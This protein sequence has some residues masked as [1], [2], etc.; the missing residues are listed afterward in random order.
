[1]IKKIQLSS[2]GKFRNCQIPCGPVTVIEGANESGKTTLFDALLDGLCKPKGSTEP[3]KLLRQRYGDA[4]SVNLE[5]DGPELQFSSV[6][7]LNLFAIRAGDLSVEVS[8]D[9]EWLSRV[10]AQLFSG[11]IDPLAVAEQLTRQIESRA[12]GTL[13]AEVRDLQEKVASL[14]KTLQELQQQRELSLQEEKESIHSEEEL[15]R[16]QSELG[17]L[18]KEEESLI[19]SLEQQNLYRARKELFQVKGFLES[20]DKLQQELEEMPPYTEEEQRELRTLERE[21][22]ELDSQIQKTRT[23]LEEARKELQN[24]QPEIEHLSGQ[25]RKLQQIRD[26]GISLKTRLQDRSS[27]IDRKVLYTFRPIFLVLAALVFLLGVA[28]AGVAPKDLWILPLVAGVVGAALLAFFGIKRESVE[29]DTRFRK[30]V[31]GVCEE[32]MK[33]G[34]DP[35]PETTWENF[36][37]TLTRTDERLNNNRTQLEELHGKEGSIRNRIEALEGDLARYRHE[38]EEIGAALRVKCERLKVRD[39][40]HY[41]AQMEKRSEKESRLRELNHLIEEA[42]KRYGQADAIGLGSCVREELERIQR[43]ITEP[44]KPEAEVKR[45]EN[46]LRQRKERRE[47]LESEEKR[48]IQLVHR[49]KG[50]VSGAYRDLPERIVKTE[51]ELSRKKACVEEKKRSWKGARRAAELFRS[52]SADTDILL[53]SLSEE[54]AH[55]FSRIAPAKEEG[56]NRK[57]TLKTFSSLKDTEV[58]DAGGNLWPFGNIERKE[59]REGVFLSTGTRDAFLLAARLTLARKAVQG[60]GEAILVMDEPFLTLDDERVNR[61]LEVLEEFQRATGWQIFLFTKEERLA[62]KV[63]SRFGQLTKRIDLDR[64][65]LS[66]FPMPG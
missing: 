10:K 30:A 51:Q 41:A 29:E 43:Q 47:T 44:E 37:N 31:K 42:C 25:A 27:F 18:Q 60:S 54:I 62:E 66:L 2:F 63:R 6:D 12:K 7:F 40:A 22:Q 20:A 26:F 3:G 21:L 58:M 55:V 14:E 23:L 36:L 48:L 56:G 46:M 19:R 61:A 52:L 45:L 39:S 17:T 35:I 28:G 57:V 49:K 9:S 64:M 15:E 1:M 13:H 8:K 50:E 5:F 11:G 65:D 32:W 59:N 16:I 34:G 33:E 53:S 24:L 4:R 38:R